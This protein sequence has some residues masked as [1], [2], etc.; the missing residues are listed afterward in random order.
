MKIQVTK[1]IGVKPKR[2]DVIIKDNKLYVIG[3]IPIPNPCYEIRAQAKIDEKNHELKIYIRRVRTPKICVQV[4]ATAFVEIDTEIQ[5]KGLWQI[6]VYLD[7]K[8]EKYVSLR[9]P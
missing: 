6:R 3:S 1:T 7:G 5:L 9:F 2:I 8:E 4:L